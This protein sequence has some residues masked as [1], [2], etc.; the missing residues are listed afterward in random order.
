MTKEEEIL[1]KHVSLYF[2]SNHGKSRL[3]GEGEHGGAEW[4]TDKAIAA[5]IYLAMDEYAKQFGEKLI[6]WLNDNDFKFT[7]WKDNMQSDVVNNG[8]RMHASEIIDL[9]IEQQTKDK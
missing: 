2:S 5:D 9:F 6:G 7:S 1:N 8:A 4:H 3:N